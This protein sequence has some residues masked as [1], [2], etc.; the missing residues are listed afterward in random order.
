MQSFGYFLGGVDADAVC[1]W[2]YLKKI[3]N[4]LS[5]ARTTTQKLTKNSFL[6]LS[7]PFSLARVYG[8][9]SS[10]LAARNIL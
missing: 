3:V 10:L 2:H 6:T 1:K 4:T 9:L 7:T 5:N 8:L